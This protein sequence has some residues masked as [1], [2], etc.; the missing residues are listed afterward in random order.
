M[1]ITDWD[2]MRRARE[3]ITVCRYSEAFMHFNSI[4]PANSEIEFLSNHLIV[5]EL[6]KLHKD[7]QI[8]KYIPTARS[9]AAHKTAAQSNIHACKVYQPF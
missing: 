8:T 2:W 9:L 1:S 5:I 3:A 4:C 7:D 6:N